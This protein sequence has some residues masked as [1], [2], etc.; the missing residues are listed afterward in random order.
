MLWRRPDVE[1]PDNRAMADRCLRSSEKSQKHDDTLAKTY[2]EIIDG[3][4]TKGHAHKLTSEETAV[5]TKKQW[6][7][8]HPA[9]LNP[10]K[11][12][13]VRIVMDTKSK[14]NGVF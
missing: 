3:Y 4:V 9:V 7:L 6:L 11:P 5:Q 1:L 2:N 10:N 13:K 14:H 8:P 12:G